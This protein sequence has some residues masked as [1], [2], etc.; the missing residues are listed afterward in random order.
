MEK[1]YL[2][3]DQ[4]KEL[5]F[6]LT[7][8]RK[9]SAKD[10]YKINAI[11]LLGDGWTIKAV[12]EAL[13]LSDET[14]SKYKKDYADGGIAMLQG[15]NYRGSDCMLTGTQ[16]R[17]FCEELDNNIY[18]TTAQAI[19]FVEKAF[20]LTYSISG[21]KDLLHR[22][23]YS[24]KKPKLVPGKS[25]DELQ[26]VFIEQY[27]KFMTAKPDN[28]AV[29]FMD[30]VHPQHNTMA[31]YGWIKKGEERKL[32][33]NS[34]RQ[35]VNLHGAINIE[36]LDVEVVEGEKVNSESTVELLRQ[37]ERSCS[38]ASVIYIILDNARYHYSKVVREYLKGSR[39]KLVF[40]PAYSPNLNLIERLWR[41]FKKK[42]L[43]N[44]YYEK[45]KDFKEACLGFFKNIKSYESEVRSL[46]T[47][48]FHLI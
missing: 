20:S 28:A 3:N 23:G 10:S 48:D 14:I 41:L 12:A 39:V 36:T 11:L 25:D 42:I 2:T 46:M 38:L 6:E 29:Y 34:G 13:F 45:F 44:K 24:Y 5:I 35:R 27:E 26:E 9:S 31:A 16:R 43:Y 21:M 17:I 47:E 33:T 22:L 8:A 40:L 37:I 7:R 18:L 1:F 19:V 4:R 15:T 30:G 32:Q